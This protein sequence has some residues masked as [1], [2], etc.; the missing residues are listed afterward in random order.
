M[1]NEHHRIERYD[2]ILR[3]LLAWQLVARE[4]TDGDGSWQ[5]VPEAQ[6]RLGQLARNSTPPEAGKLVYLDH[7]CADCQQRRPTRPHGAV[8]L[9]DAC[10]ELREVPAAATVSADG[11]P[12]RRRP[13]TRSR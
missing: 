7:R 3:N 6:E 4:G 8:F 11:K 9:C 13:L 2:P 10:A 1:E 12:R 5:L